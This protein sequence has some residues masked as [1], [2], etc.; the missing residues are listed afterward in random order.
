MAAFKCKYCGGDIIPEEGQSLV[1]CEYCQREQSLTKSKSE[2]VVNLFN[3][4]NSLRMR[5]EFDKSQEVYEKILAEEPGDAEAHWGIVLCKYGIEYV[6]E[7]DNTYSGIP[8]CHRAQFE[9]IFAD[10]DYIAAVENADDAQKAYYEAEGKKISEL[11]KSILQVVKNE[12]PFDVFIC[13]KEK[14][15][16][17]NRTVDSG[18]A[19]DIYYQLTE[20]GF[21]V[22]Y[23]AIT[24]EDKLGTAYEPYIFAALNSAKVMLVLG[25]KP[26]YFN[27]VWVKNEWARY[28]KLM[29]KD[30]TRSLFPC[31]RD[32]DA[33]EL[34]EE[35]AHLQAQDMSK[36]GFITDII[37]GIKKLIRK[38]AP[39]AKTSD[40]GAMST[41]GAAVPLLKRTF[42]CIE[43]RDYQKAEA[44]LEQ[45]LN[46]DPEC[47][48]AYI[49]K[50]L[51]EK[52]LTTRDQLYSMETELENEPM[53]VRALR[54]AD[55]KYKE[56]LKGY[57][58]ESLY[59]RACS[60]MAK[61]SIEKYNEAILLLD[62]IPEYKDVS[63]KKNDCLIG[64]S[65]INYREAIR[66]KVEALNQKNTAMAADAAE[67]FAALGDYKDSGVQIGQCNELKNE[68]Q[69]AIAMDN[70]QRAT[71]FKDA[72]SVKSH[73]DCAIAFFSGLFDYKDAKDQAEE[74]KNLKTEAL[75]SIGQ[76]LKESADKRNNVDLYV[77]ASEVFDQII[78]YKDSNELVIACRDRVQEIRTEEKYQS[79]RQFV[80][81]DDIKSLTE[82]ISVY[83]SIIDWKDSESLL[84]QARA[85]LAFLK[86]RDE[87]EKRRNRLSS[88]LTN[89][90]EKE[91]KKRNEYHGVGKLKAKKIYYHIM[92]V[93]CLLAILVPVMSGVKMQSILDDMNAPVMWYEVV[94]TLNGSDD[95][96]FDEFVLFEYEEYDDLDKLVILYEQG[97]IGG[98]AVLLCA[99]SINMIITII[100]DG[101]AKI[102]LLIVPIAN[103]FVG[104][105]YFFLSI[106][107]LFLPLSSYQRKKLKGYKKAKKEL[108]PLMKRK[109]EIEA[110]LKTINL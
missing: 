2:I 95:T 44:L 98:L 18:I 41:T 34:P 74:C 77:Q 26:E 4:A 20:E 78:G 81:R 35:F 39:K 1:T 56:V 54:F 6:K 92:G 84:A 3:R 82:A 43:D 86:D 9:S 7:N 105:K 61:N 85:R 21:K 16:N 33:Y 22:F 96:K 80:A 68:I 62:R 103:L 24:L 57:R 59:R 88:E 19:N 8:T 51:I 90:N 53:Y 91:A 30:R 15:E 46:L 109:K 67:K 45:V 12:K 108:V 87:K 106:K 27:A 29:K 42:L 71:Q 100:F 65:E 11:Q 99:I 97:F 107:N 110:E 48:E 52:K 17:G 104:I 73:Y 55:D 60:A 49:A 70:K 101:F 75:Y 38:E 64:I 63:E 47:A 50:M 58:N 25:T 79:A 32:M 66:L 102:F 76:G 69:Y 36:V 10:V 40:S 31:Y 83:E 23:A 72:P 5:N 89:I 28:L 93:I 94:D 14:D 13:Y 37:R